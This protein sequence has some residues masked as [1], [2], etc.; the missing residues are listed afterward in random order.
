MSRSVR[1]IVLLVGQMLAMTG[2]RSEVIYAP[3]TPGSTLE[4]PR[5]R[6]SHPHFRTEWWY[7]TGWVHDENGREFG[8]QITFFRH[9]TGLQEDNLSA[10]APTRPMRGH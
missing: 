8:V 1:W 4:F 3:V 6:G 7:L 9:R 10:F 5:D 2:V